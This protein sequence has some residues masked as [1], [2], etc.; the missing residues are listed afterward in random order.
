MLHICLVVAQG[1]YHC[2]WVPITPSNLE[3][4]CVNLDS[5]SHKSQ[6][7]EVAMETNGRVIQIMGHASEA[8]GV[9]A[10]QEASANGGPGT[11]SGLGVS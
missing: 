1:R 7:R 9:C 8:L 11:A 5:W 10:S 6:G 3:E 4:T 2:A